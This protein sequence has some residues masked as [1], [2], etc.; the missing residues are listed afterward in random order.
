M[1]KCP[2]CGGNVEQ[3]IKTSDTIETIIDDETLVITD[4]PAEQCSQC[5]ETFHDEAAGR[6]ID[7]QI[8]SFKILRNLRLVKQNNKYTIQK[9]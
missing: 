5:N 3:T 9:A 4:I 1:Y 7:Q 6:Y 2:F 8:A